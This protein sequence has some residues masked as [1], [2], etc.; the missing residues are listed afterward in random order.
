MIKKL[1]FGLLFLSICL[2]SYATTYTVDS[3]VSADDVTIDWLN[4][5]KNTAIDALNSFPGANLEAA[6]VTTAALDNNANPEY[7]WGESFNEYVYTGLL[8]PTSVTL[9][10]TTTAGTAYIKEDSTLKMKR[11]V[12]DATAKTYTA[13]KDTYVDLSA[14]GTYTYSEV[15]NSAAAPV[16]AADSIRLAIVVTDTDN[17]TSV[18]DSRVLGVQLATNEDFYIAGFEGV[19]SDANYIT[20]DTGVVY[21]GSTRV[22]K[23]ATTALNVGTAANYVNG[24]SERT[25]DDWIYVYVN[26]TGSM[27]LDNNPPDYHDTDGNAVGIKYYFKN[28]TDYWRFLF[29]VRLNATGL[30]EIDY[31]YQQDGAYMWDI[32]VEVTTT[33]SDAAWSGALD[34]SASIPPMSTYALF[35]LSA[36]DNA[37]VCGIWLRPNG[38]TLYSNPDGS[39]TSQSGGLYTS[40]GG[41]SSDQITG[42][43][44][45]NTD[46]DQKIQYWNNTGDSSTVVTVRGFKFHR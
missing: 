24:A 18:T 25:T 11:V 44:W 32:P 37:A 40:S 20:M 35:A 23:I 29:P 9:A 14:S 16:V 13:S 21:V 5:L 17:V 34:C 38:S 7:R 15:A 22:E 6:S 26:N 39:G 19:T 30:G 1:L 45:C 12:K 3:L 43:L 41:A 42:Q 31:F 27:K 10:S 28:G 4:D 46:G 36:S 8:P 2:T 33:V